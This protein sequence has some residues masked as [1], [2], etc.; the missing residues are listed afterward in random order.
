MKIET[1]FLMYFPYSKKQF[2]VFFSSLS[3]VVQIGS[4]VISRD[5]SSGEVFGVFVF[6]L[7][8]FNPLCATP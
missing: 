8:V 2:S 5:L 3:Y 4:I 7:I 6:N 1:D